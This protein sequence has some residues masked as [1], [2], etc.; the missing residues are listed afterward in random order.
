MLFCIV[1]FSISLDILSRLCESV[2]NQKITIDK[3]YWARNEVN[4]ILFIGIINI[5][6]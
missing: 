5:I 2:K 1:D 4:Y 3:I 6:I